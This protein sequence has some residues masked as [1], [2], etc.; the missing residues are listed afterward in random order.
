MYYGNIALISTACYTNFDTTSTIE[1]REL[2]GG[3]ALFLYNRRQALPA[4]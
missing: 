4:R 3:L 2:N 1:Q